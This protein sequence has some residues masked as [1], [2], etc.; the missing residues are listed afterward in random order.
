MKHRILTI[1]A[2]L[3]LLLT[4]SCSK[5]KQIELKSWAVQ[6][7]SL[8]GSRGADATLLL[9]ID[10]PAM[11]FTLSDVEGV[12]YWQGNEYVRF[13]ALPITVE[14]HKQAVYPLESEALLSPS[15]SMLQLIGLARKIDVTEVTSDVH[16]RVTLRSGVSKAFDLKGLEVGKMLK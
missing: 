8:K 12:L 5:I 9:E 13:S 14:G 11:Q 15:V 2:I 4:A 16:V 7:V 6:E 3:A 10:N 1:S